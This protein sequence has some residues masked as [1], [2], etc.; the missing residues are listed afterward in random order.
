ML[1]AVS[2]SVLLVAGAGCAAAQGI[3]EIDRVVVYPETALVAEG[4]PEACIVASSTDEGAAAVAAELQQGLREALGVEL[5]LVTDDEV[6]PERLGPVGEPWRQTN[7]IIVGNLDAN[8][9]ILPLYALFLCGADSVYP[10]GDGHELR[11]VSNPWGTGRNAIVVGGSSVEGMRAAAQALLGALPAGQ[12][13]TVVLP[14]LLETMPGGAQV[15]AFASAAA[16]AGGQG[17]PSSQ[18]EISRF[19]EAANSYHWTGDPRWA[20]VAGE[21][22]RFFN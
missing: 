17:L 9:A 18:A 15:A 7:L 5:P 13:G 20:E 6:C 16:R 2:V 22:M 4:Q 11:T 21:R 12:E 1:R 14:R 19:W 8:R 3:P 10:G